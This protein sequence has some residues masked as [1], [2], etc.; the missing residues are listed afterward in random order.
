VG[1]EL[2]FAFAPS[3]TRVLEA[4][5]LHFVGRLKLIAT[6]PILRAARIARA[7]GL[8]LLIVGARVVHAQGATL[9]RLEHAADLEPHRD[10]ATFHLPTSEIW[11]EAAFHA[12]VSNGPGPLRDRFLAIG[13]IERE[14]PLIQRPWGLVA[15]SI[16]LLPAVY[17]NGNRRLQASSC[18]TLTLC[19]VSVRYPSFGVGALP[20]SLHFMSAA[21]HGVGIVVGGG[22]GAVWFT[23]QIPSEMGTRF[24]FL[25]QGG[26]DLDIRLLRKCWAILGY[27]HVHL[28]NGGLGTVNVGIDAN[29]FALGILW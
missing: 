5:A 13:G 20:L 29:L 24:N 25:A 12:P 19:Y 8:P 1:S 26:A 16:S 28:S 22:A 21:L 3:W 15:T 10:S 18:G 9:P 14:F 7:V 27:R 6:E 23:Q 2:V 11:T 17:T 4:H